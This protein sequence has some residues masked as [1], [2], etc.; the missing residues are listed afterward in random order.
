MTVTVSDAAPRR[1]AGSSVSRP[2]AATPAAPPADMST[3]TGLIDSASTSTPEAWLEAA[4]SHV[5]DLERELAR[6]QSQEAILKHDLA[7]QEK[8]SVEKLREMAAELDNVRRTNER[9][10]AKDRARLEHEFDAKLSAAVASKEKEIISYHER[11]STLK[12]SEERMRRTAEVLRLQR[13]LKE[14]EGIARQKL[15]ELNHLKTIRDV[16]L[17]LECM[18]HAAT[19][20]APFQVEKD[21][22]TKALMR[23]NSSLGVTAIDA[24]SHDIAARGIPTMDQLVERF[25]GLKAPVRQAAYVGPNGGLLSHMLSYGLSFLSRHPTGLVAGTDVECTLL[26]E[27]FAFW[28]L[29][30]CFRRF[31]ASFCLFFDFLCLC[32]SVANHVAAAILSRANYYL[33]IG[34]VDSATREMNQLPGWAHHVASDWLKDARDW[35]EFHQ[36]IQVVQADCDL[37]RLTTIPVV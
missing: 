8:V 3:L 37:A 4:K 36:A 23:A 24:I 18:Q 20:G 6:L 19:T 28:V 22:L 7:V 13:V 29:F 14:I 2:D 30:A 15:S 26:E 21:K 12:M 17:V 25:N 32:F 27:R 10:L 1:R 33:D 5:A 16:A 31:F 11:R 35:L 9:V 34:D